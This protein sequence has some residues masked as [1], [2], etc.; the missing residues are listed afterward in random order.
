MSEP[1][2]SGLQAEFWND[3]GGRMWVERI[4]E[5][6]RVIAPLGDVVRERA[7]ARAGETVLDV[8]CGDGRNSRELA[9]EVGPDGHVVAVDVSEIILDYARRQPALPENLE[10]VLSDAATADLGEAR[11]DLLFSRFGIM[12]FEDPKAA[13]THLRRTLKPTGRV[14]FLCWQ[15]PQLNP[16]LSAP[17]K[18]IFE[19]M[20]PPAP[21]APRSPGPFAFAEADWV[22]EIMTDAGFADISIDGIEM[23]ITM[24]PLEE[25][26]YY[27]MRFGPAIDA[28]KEATDD[29][30]QRVEDG[31]RTAFR[32]M[33]SDGE[34]RGPT[35][36]W[37]VTATTA[38]T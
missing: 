10:F 28:L 13:L 22:Q 35:A 11:F 7:A 37:L 5:T 33:V 24:G 29:E 17:T 15:A 4:E 32:P 18:A 30:R 2:E 38:G 1:I 8:G 34:V 3:T 31:I 25:A 6:H 36:T 9:A 23:D 16:W 27:M 14:A 21:P 20:P 12:F 26:V 19:V